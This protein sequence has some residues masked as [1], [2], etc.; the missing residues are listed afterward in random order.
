[1]RA[2]RK[3]VSAQV[4]AAIKAGGVGAQELQCALG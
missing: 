4:G 2:E 1:M 3:Q